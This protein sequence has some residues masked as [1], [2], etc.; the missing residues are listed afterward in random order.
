MSADVLIFPRTLH[1][2]RSR[3]EEMALFV[4]VGILLPDEEILVR[5]SDLLQDLHVESGFFAD[6]AN[7]TI[8]QGFAL[9]A[10]A[11]GQREDGSD[12]HHKNGAMPVENQFVRARPYGVGL[13]GHAIAELRCRSAHRSARALFCIRRRDVLC[14]TYRRSI[15]MLGSAD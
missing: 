8:R 7:Q 15:A 9:M 2:N 12:L 14:G 4:D 1:T 11:T 6:F 5:L 3:R 13:T 10:P